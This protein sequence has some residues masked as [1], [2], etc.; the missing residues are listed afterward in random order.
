MILFHS[1]ELIFARDG[2]LRRS[3]YCVILKATDPT[4]DGTITDSANKT[5][6]IKTDLS[7]IHDS[8]NPKA[9][10]L[11]SHPENMKVKTLTFEQK[12]AK[13]YN[14]DKV[15]ETSTNDDGPKHAKKLN[16]TFPAEVTVFRTAQNYSKVTQPING[17]DFYGKNSPKFKITVDP[18]D[19]FGI[20]QQGG[21]VFVKRSESLLSSLTAQY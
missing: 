3:P 8:E 11:E 13:T 9:M 2:I 16:I 20:T 14:W 5:I 15:D 17:T 6:C 1:T 10:R 19:A 12:L 18:L 7:K 21:I 4:V